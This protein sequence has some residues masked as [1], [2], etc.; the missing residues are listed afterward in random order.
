MMHG[1][2]RGEQLAKRYWQKLF[3]EYCICDLSRYKENKACSKKHLI[4]KMCHFMQTLQGESATR[5]Q[6]FVDLAS[7][8]L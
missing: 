1:I 3:K 4:H 2:N 7:V 5:G 8:P 6:G